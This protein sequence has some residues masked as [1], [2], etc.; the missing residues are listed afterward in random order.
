MQGSVASF[1]VL[2][3]TYRFRA[4]DPFAFPA[5][6]TG[7]VFRGALGSFLQSANSAAYRV[8]FEPTEPGSTAGKTPP[9]PFV[10][11]SRTVEGQNYSPG[12]IFSVQLN[13]FLTRVELVDALSA[14][15]TAMGDAGFGPTRSRAALL[16]P[17]EQ[18]RHSL[19]LDEA[20]EPT[21]SLRVCFQTPTELKSNGEISPPGPFF[22]LVEQVYERLRRLITLYGSGDPGQNLK[23]LC[24]DARSIALTG[25]DLRPIEV[26]RR[27]TRLGQTHPLGGFLGWAEYSG[28]LGPFL[29]LLQ[30]A[31]FIGVG[32]HTVWGNGEI[33]SKRLG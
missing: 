13:L 29:P 21:R 7:N 16:L 33:S 26:S 2:S 14:A 5:F 25:T 18:V 19:R 20:F 12:E 17:P 9:R 31:S 6:L 32:R 4:L 28:N 24:K 3:L 22:V 23:S 30:A 10:L 27:G 8:L 1:E 15:L 11:R